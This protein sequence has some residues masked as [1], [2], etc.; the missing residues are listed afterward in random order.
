[1]NPSI[2]VQVVEPQ[3]IKVHIEPIGSSLAVSE[4]ILEAGRKYSVSIRL[5][6]ADNNQIA[7]S[8]V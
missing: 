5:Y 8:H 1:M 4:F 6:D 7:Q 3:A 2:Y